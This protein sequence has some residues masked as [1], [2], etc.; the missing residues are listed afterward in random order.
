ME[1]PVYSPTALHM[2]L[3]ASLHIY[4]LKAVGQHTLLQPN[5]IENRVT[6]VQH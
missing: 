5:S 2:A 1:A 6:E 4:I 3:C